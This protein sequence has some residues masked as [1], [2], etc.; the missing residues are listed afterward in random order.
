MPEGEMTVGELIK[1]L[2]EYDPSKIIVMSSDLEGPMM[3]LGRVWDPEMC[4]DEFEGDLFYESDCEDGK[5]C[6]C[7]Y[8]D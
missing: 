5:P 1:A 4:F 7:L 8:S 2:Q 3:T 6:I